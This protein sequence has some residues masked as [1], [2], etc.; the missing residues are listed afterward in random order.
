[1]L[2]QTFV[3]VESDV[4]SW[5]SDWIVDWIEPVVQQ[6]WEAIVTA[7]SSIV[8]ILIFIFILIDVL[9]ADSASP[10]A[11]IAVALIV[12]TTNIIGSVANFANGFFAK[13]PS[14]TY[15]VYQGEYDNFTESWSGYM[16]AQASSLWRATS[17][18]TAFGPAAVEGGLKG[19]AWTN[20]LDPFQTAGLSQVT[21]TFFDILLST[22]IINDMWQSDGWYIAFVPYGNLGNFQTTRGYLP[23]TSNVTFTLEDCMD[24]WWNDPKR[25]NYVTCTLNYGGTPGMTILAQASSTNGGTLPDTEKGFSTPTINFTFAYDDALQSSLT[26]NALYGFNYNYTNTQLYD[27]LNDGSYNISSEFVIALDSPGL[28]NIDVCVITQMSMIPGSKEFLR[29]GNGDKYLDYIY[30]DP[31]SCAKFTSQGGSFVNYAPSKIVDA[32]NSTECLAKAT[33]AYL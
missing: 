5:V 12:G 15:L 16:Q 31:C 25:A 21:R 11:G 4:E 10:I 27:T 13:P 23:P 18:D 20:E 30:L 28:Y 14:D 24:Y 1:M 33:L 32:I 29:A 7:V 2:Y 17:G 8:G 3:T 6:D 19:G 26:A 9:S 22:S